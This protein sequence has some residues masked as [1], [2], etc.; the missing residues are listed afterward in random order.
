V[1][2]AAAWGLDSLGSRTVS[3]RDGES[4]SLSLSAVG[5]FQLIK[6]KVGAR[7]SELCRAERATTDECTSLCTQHGVHKL[8]RQP[9]YNCTEASWG[10]RESLEMAE[11]ALT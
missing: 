6:Y 4:S 2:A 1:A 11:P 9:S 8:N 10:G 7:G 5:C 3:A